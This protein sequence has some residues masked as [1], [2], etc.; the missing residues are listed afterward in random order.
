MSSECFYVLS[1]PYVCVG[2]ASRENVSSGELVEDVDEAYK[3]Y[4]PQQLRD[5]KLEYEETLG[6]FQVVKVTVQ[7]SFTFQPLPDRDQ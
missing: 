3:V 2:Y 4:D 6:H 1:D 5:L 7:T